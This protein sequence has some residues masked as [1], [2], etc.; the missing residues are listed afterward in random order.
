MFNQKIINLRRLG[1]FGLTGISL[2]FYSMSSLN[3]SQALAQQ[4]TNNKINAKIK[5]TS[6]E[7]NIAIL[8][9]AYDKVA[10]T[11]SM[12]LIAK[13][14]EKE[15]NEKL[16]NQRLNIAKAYLTEYLK[17]RDSKTVIIAKGEKNK[18]GFGTIEI[19][20]SGKLFGIL[21]IRRNGQLIV[22]SCEPDE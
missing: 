6:C 2:L 17:I 5:P 7:E 9:S 14:G 22:G 18:K 10:D 3:Y 15:Y 11:E 20:V 21:V 19:Y 13:L 16:N 8:E 12:I 1:I 4:I